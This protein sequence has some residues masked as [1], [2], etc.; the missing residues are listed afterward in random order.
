MVDNGIYCVFKTYR[1]GIML[2]VL[3]HSQQHQH[4]GE[5]KEIQV[6]IIRLVPGLGETYGNKARYMAQVGILI[7]K[8]Q[9]RVSIQKPCI[10]S[11]VRCI[12][13]PDFC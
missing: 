2:V 3:C 11:S 13:N 5:K 10:S 4:T 9:I 12:H 6:N 8:I 7:N 1:T